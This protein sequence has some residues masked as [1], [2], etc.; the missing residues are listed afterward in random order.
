MGCGRRRCSSTSN[1]SKLRQ[2]SF[3][4][5]DETYAGV[6]IQI[7]YF[8]YIEIYDDNTHKNSLRML[9]LFSLSKRVFGGTVKHANVLAMPR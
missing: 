4:V 8:S 7:F 1:A 6:I 9:T 3:Q 5:M 2:P